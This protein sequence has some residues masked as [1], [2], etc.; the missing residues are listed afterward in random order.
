MSADEKREG[1]ELERYREGFADALIW[2]LE[3]FNLDSED[4]DAL[5][6]ALES[7]PWE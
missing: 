6:E 3:R 1:R 7:G 5:N 2:V 4:E